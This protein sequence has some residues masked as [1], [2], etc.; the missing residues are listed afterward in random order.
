[1]NGTDWVQQSKRPAE[2]PGAVAATNPA[3]PPYSR[4]RLEVSMMMVSRDT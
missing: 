4:K 2:W 3:H 1:M